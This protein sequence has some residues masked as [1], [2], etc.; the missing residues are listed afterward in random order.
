E[1]GDSPFDLLYGKG[2]TASTENT[3]TI[4]NQGSNDVIVFLKRL[5]DDKVIRN[6]YVKAN[7][8]Y[9]FINIPNS[10]CYAKFYYGND[11]NPNL[12]T[13]NEKTGGFEKNI[14][15]VDAER[16]LMTFEVTEDD[17]Y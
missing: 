15:F 5:E 16:D 12:K 1:N 4:K 10:T 6:H 8:L 3:L 14:Q 17:R 13:K 7:T 2:I 9:T 11:W